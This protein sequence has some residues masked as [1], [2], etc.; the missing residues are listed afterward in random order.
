MVLPGSQLQGRHLTATCCKRIQTLAII[1][2]CVC[3]QLLPSNHVYGW[4]E[5]YI[6]RYTRCI[7]GN[8]GREISIHTVMY[9]VYTRF[10]PTLIMCVCTCA[11]LTAS[12]CKEGRLCHR[13]YCKGSA[14]RL[15]MLVCDLL[16]LPNKSVCTSYLHQLVKKAGSAIVATAREA[17]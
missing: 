2:L 6:Y 1:D 9:G 11:Y 17:Q 15:Q 13:C 7:Y 16:I 8:S 10:W 5:A 14:V 4:P 3:F 12:A